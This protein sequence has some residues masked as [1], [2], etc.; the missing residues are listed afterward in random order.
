MVK[1]V[2]RAR[3]AL[4]MLCLLACGRHTPIDPVR[5]H[6]DAT[7]TT[8]RGS[9]LVPVPSASAAVTAAH[10]EPRARPRPS[11]WEVPGQWVILRDE[12][13]KSAALVSV[14]SSASEARPIV[15]AA[16]G[17]QSNPEWNCPRVRAAYGPTPWI[18]CLHPSAHLGTD[19]S[20][21]SAKQIAEQIER[22]VALLLNKVGMR[23]DST[24]MHFIGHSQGAVQG[25]IALAQLRSV[26]FR[27]I[28]LFEGPPNSVSGVAALLKAATPEHVLL[29]AGS[30]WGLAQTRQLAT[31]L[32]AGGVDTHAR[33]TATGHFFEP[34]VYAAI[35]HELPWLMPQASLKENPAPPQLPALEGTAAEELSL[36]GHRVAIADVPA[37][38]AEPRP[39]VLAAHAA[40][41]GPEWICAAARELFGPTPIV[42]C[43]DAAPSA[44]LVSE[45]LDAAAPRL[46]AYLAIQ[47]AIYFG[48]SQGAILAPAVWAVPGQRL[49]FT[50]ALLFR[51]L[52]HD[53]KATANHMRHAGV[54]R[55]A[56][57]SGERGSIGDETQFAHAL[58]DGGIE[59]M[60]YPCFTHLINQDVVKFLKP[61]ATWLSEPDAELAAVR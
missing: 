21:A 37:G 44:Q 26:H 30:T 2:I 20:W 35:H 22:S 12:A 24:D 7:S 46:G 41:V 9:V 25:P 56:M 17:S 55:L 47:N 54:R 59:A 3:S 49:H 42:L 23:A 14:G 18:V 1:H 58:R 15:V 33:E 13:G 31:L 53:A 8:P 48:D 36:D 6:I 38:T 51:G 28:T 45:V 57:T 34:K 39:I 61:L 27:T 29:V 16:H 52:P 4:A 5:Q 32:Q 43:P 50:R 60:E 11:E 19:A 40:G 10:E